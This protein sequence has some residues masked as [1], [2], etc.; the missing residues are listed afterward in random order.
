MQISE[1]R[2]VNPSILKWARERLNL[3]PEQVAEEAR[4]LRRHYYAPVSAQELAQWEKGLSEPELE[5]LETLSEIYLCPVG[6]FFLDS[7]P[8][9]PLP[10][11]FRGLAR[12]KAAS[13][14]PTTHRTLRRFHDLAQWTVD[15]IESLSIPWEVK[16][17]P[18]EY[19][20]DLSLVNRLV[21]E[22]RE[23]FGWTKELQSRFEGDRE[24]AFRW[25]RKAIENEGIFCF[26]MK[27]E[28]SEVRGAS[29]WIGSRFPFILVN[30]QDA[31]AAS[32]RIFTLLHEYAHLITAKEGLV[33][34][35]RGLQADK[36]P[37]PFANRFAARMLL[38]PEELSQ[39]LKEIGYDRPRETWSDRVLDEICE[40][41]I[42]SRDVVAIMLQEMGLAPADFYERK[43]Q[44]WERRWEKR[45]PWGRGGGRPTKKELK[46]REL[47]YSLTKLL[48]QHSK[49]PSFPWLDVSYVLDMK[50]KKAADFIQWVRETKL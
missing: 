40:P 32:G 31:E 20:P 3:T 21:Q 41:F 47:G 27:L 37:E 15:F 35:F 18:G 42:V 36:N 5:H 8:Q 44:Q 29:L 39:R 4:K 26:A 22:K 34:D 11:S 25:W 1:T 7:T 19:A 17:R 33:C 46:F 43:R 13:L 24:E 50:I 28:P 6:Y 48:A 12:E 9:E 23:Y 10:L 14:S 2:W 16:V 45:K 30:R 38:S 49:R